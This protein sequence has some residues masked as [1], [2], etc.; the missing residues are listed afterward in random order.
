MTNVFIPGSVT[1]I[2]GGTGAA[3]F[4]YCMNLVSITVDPTNWAMSSVDGVLFNKK[5]TSLLEYPMGRRGSYAIPSGVG[6]IG[7][8]AFDSCTNLTRV[9][10]PNTVTNIMTHGFYSCSCLTSVTIPSS[11]ETIGNFAFTGCDYLT[12][13]FFAGNAPVVWDGPVFSP[14][15]VILPKTMYYVP[16]TIGWGPTYAGYPT[17]PLT[18]SVSAPTVQGSQLSFSVAGPSGISVVVE[19]CRSL[20]STT[21]LP[22]QVGNLSTGTLQV[23][24]ADWANHPRQ[25]YRAR[26]E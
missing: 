18:L 19:S 22:I 4:D 15:W 25:F 13:I 1:G 7:S 8:Y 5:Q 3:P 9:T 26:L 14:E 2:V 6:R 17:A 21:W 16:G 10:I 24:D 11:V 12:N 23:T 20:D